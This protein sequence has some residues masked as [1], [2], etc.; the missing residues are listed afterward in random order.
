MIR[1]EHTRLGRLL[2][3]PLING[4]VAIALIVAAV[5]ISYSAENGLPFVPTYKLSVDIPDAAQLTKNS[6]VRIGGTRV[7][8]VLQ[9]DAMPGTHG[10]PPF[11]R[12]SLSLDQGVGPLPADTTV[13]MRLGS[14]LGGKY[15][16]LQP[17]HAQRTIPSGG[18]LSLSHARTLVEVDDALR[19]FDPPTA[20]ALQKAIIGLGDSFTGEGDATN[21]AITNVSALLPPLD[22][23]L[24]TLG[25]P[26]T[27]LGRFVRSTA[28]TAGTLAPVSAQLADLFGQAGHTLAAVAA[29]GDSLGADLDALPGT[30]TTGTV[31][32]RHLTPVLAQAAAL[33]RALR[34]AGRLLPPA[35]GALDGI[36]R[37]ATP[38]ARHI[39]SAVPPLNGALNAA[40]RFGT[41]P[42]STGALKVLGTND[43]GS[44]GGS[45]FLGLGA[46]LRSVASAQLGCNTATVW[47]SN[48]SSSVSEGDASGSWIRVLPIFEEDQSLQQSAPASDLHDN[49]Y[50]VQTAGDCQ[51]GNEP[52]TNGQVIGNPAS[53]GDRR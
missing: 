52:Y 34:P 50:P 33:V 27:Q 43:L 42:A 9:I 32:L 45:L 25:D 29:A 35:T 40:Q 23:V 31:A 10:R 11:A 30:E 49:P 26:G 37:L 18:H 46:I 3:N 41:D 6:D 53:A 17:G 47:I 8:Q 21:Q 24:G 14:L 2:G 39:P 1:R 48:L 12:L 13:V 5:V 36:V 19:V 15:I 51:S 22:A 44:F 7:G 28:S 20:R 16:E 4:L 38:V